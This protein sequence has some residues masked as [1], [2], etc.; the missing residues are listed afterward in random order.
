MAVACAAAL[1]GCSVEDEVVQFGGPTMGSTYSVKYVRRADGPPPEQ[2]QRDAD[3]FL[4]RLDEELSTY[5][6]DSSLER[7][8]A[9]AAGECAAVPESVLMLLQAGNTLAEQSA[10]ALDLTLEPLLNLWGF[11]PKSPDGQQ[12]PTAAEI[13]EIMQRVGQRHL[14]VEDEQLCKDAPVELDFNSIAAGYAVDE[15]VAQ[16]KASGVESFLVEITGELR[17]EGVKPDGKPWRVA[18]EAPRDDERVAQR[19]IELD[20]QAISTSGDYR[21][22]FERDGKR[23]SHTL[24]PRTGS[25][26]THRL[27]AVT[28][29]HASAL[30]ADGLSTVLMVMG[31]ERGYTFAEGEGIAAFFVSRSG[32]GFETKSTTAFEALFGAGGN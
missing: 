8:N 4:A 13:D 25:P 10:G 3:R 15:I 28:V 5:R 27:A 12:V 29:A 9:L 11:G 22:Y 16:L 24:D 1:A 26:I 14:R 7:F 17:A 18:I 31:P 32:E 6:S 20:G 23:F 19:V 21:N 30:Q 2:L